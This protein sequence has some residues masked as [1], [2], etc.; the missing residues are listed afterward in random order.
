MVQAGLH[1]TTDLKIIHYVYSTVNIAGVLYIGTGG[2]G[3]WS[4]PLSEVTNV[5]S[6]AFNEALSIYPNPSTGKIRIAFQNNLTPD[7]VVLSD[8]SGKIKD[9]FL[10]TLT[11]SNTF[12][13]DGS[14]FSK[15]IYFVN[16]YTNG[17]VVSGKIIIE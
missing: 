6:T 4:R 12:E 13:I 14:G 17:N 3:V 5:S 9:E 2:A 10:P 8:L 16:V 15:G 11:R 7:R 1:P